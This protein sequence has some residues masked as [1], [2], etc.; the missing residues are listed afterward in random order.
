MYKQTVFLEVLD[1]LAEFPSFQCTYCVN[2][3]L[4]IKIILL[5]NLV[6]LF[7][8]AQIINKYVKLFSVNY[9][10]IH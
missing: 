1:F 7:I 3:T 10:M 6:Y 5:Y 9:K 4:K 8:E 2:E